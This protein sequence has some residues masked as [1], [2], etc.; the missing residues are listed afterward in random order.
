MSNL[1]E[2]IVVEGIDGSGK[3]TICKKIVN[4]LNKTSLEKCKYVREPGGTPD[5][6]I[7][8]S[9]LKTTDNLNAENQL[10]LFLLSR[11]MLVDYIAEELPGRFVIDRFIPSTYA[12]QHYLQHMDK[13]LLDKLGNQIC[14]LAESLLAKATVIYLKTSPKTALERIN[15]R[16]EKISEYETSEKLNVLSDAYDKM[17]NIDKSKKKSMFKMKNFFY[18]DTDGKSVAKVWSEVKDKLKLLDMLNRP[19]LLAK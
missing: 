9:V 6:E 15:A 11:K 16:N 12:Y 10:K 5:A 7:I 17:F 2:I 4:W 1:S 8:R 19:E 13:K 14:P 18:V 3:S